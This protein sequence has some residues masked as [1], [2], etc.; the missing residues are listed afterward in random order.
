MDRTLGGGGMSAAAKRRH[1]PS[2][3]QNGARLLAILRANLE[4]TSE[5]TPRERLQHAIAALKERRAA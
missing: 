2:P 3:Q 5:P 4:R 1:K